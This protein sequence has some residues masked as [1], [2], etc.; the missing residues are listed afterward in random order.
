M[1]I[2]LKTILLFSFISSAILCSAQKP[3]IMT[4]TKSG[5][6]MISG[7]KIDFDA[8]RNK[9]EVIGA[10]RFSSLKIITTKGTIR[11]DT[12]EIFYE[13]G[14]KQIFNPVKNIIAEGKK[15]TVNMKNKKQS[16]KSIEI[17]CKTIKGTEKAEIEIWAFK[18]EKKD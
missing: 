1:N 3:A 4:S 17:V 7:S 16:L 5:W 18:P 12:L 9:I 15:Y 11:L 14:S 6:H 2:N 10:D 8:E 13:D